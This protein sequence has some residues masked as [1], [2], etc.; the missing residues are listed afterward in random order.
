MQTQQLPPLKDLL[1]NAARELA[2]HLLNSDCPILVTSTPQR[3]SSRTS[4]VASSTGIRFKAPVVAYPDSTLFSTLTMANLQIHP[5]LQE[6][7]V[8]EDESITWPKSFAWKDW[9]PADSGTALID[10]SNYGKGDE[11]KHVSYEQ[12]REEVHR[13]LGSSSLSNIK[14]QVVGLICLPHESTFFITTFLRLLKANAI[15]YPLDPKLSSADLAQKL[16]LLCTSV[17]ICSKDLVHNVKKVLESSQTSLETVYKIVPTGNLSGHC[18]YS[19]EASRDQK[20][21]AVDLESGPE[22]T[23]T[24]VYDFTSMKRKPVLVLT[25]S[26][27]TSTPKIVPI[28]LESLLYNAKR[29]ADSLQLKRHDINL[30]VMPLFHI[31]GIMCSFLASMVAGSTV[32]CASQFEPQGFLER[33]SIYPK[34]TWYYAVPTIHKSILL[35]KQNYPRIREDLRLVR[36]GGAHLS[37][38][39]ALAL[40]AAFPK[41]TIL[42]TYS[43]SES[44]PVCSNPFGWKLQKVDTVG[45][46]IGPSV[47]IVDEQGN[48]VKYGTVG[49]VAIRGIGVTD[50]YLNRSQG[51]CFIDGEWL[52]TGDS[53]EMDRDGFLFLK[54]RLKEVAKRGGEQISLREVDE[55]LEAMPQV[56]IAVAFS[57][58]NTFWG[59][60]IAAAVVVASE[61]SAKQIIEYAKT[62]LEAYKVPAQVVVVK[63]DQIPKTSTGKYKRG[64]MAEHLSVGAVDYRAME[65]SKLAKGV[66]TPSKALYG[67]RLILAL[68]VVQHHVGIMPNKGWAIIQTFTLNMTG[69]TILAGFLLSSRTTKEVS[70]EERLDFFVTRLAAGH[71]VFLL[72]IAFALPQVFLT[73]QFDASA[74]TIVSLIWSFAITLTGFHMNFSILMYFI[75]PERVGLYTFWFLGVTWYQTMYYTCV[76]VFPFTDRIFRRLSGAPLAICTF[77]MLVLTSTLG[78]ALPMIDPDLALLNFTVVEWIWCFF[79]GNLMWRIFQISHPH[80]PRIWAVLTDTLSVGF[81]L[82][83]V[84]IILTDDTFKNPFLSEYETYLRFVV[85]R[86]NRWANEIAVLVGHQRAGSAYM[87]LWI[88][89]LAVGKGLTASLLSRK[90]LVT[91]LSPLAYSIYLFHLPLAFYYYLILHSPKYQNWWPEAGAYPIPVQWWELFIVI[92][93]TGL[94]SWVVDWFIAP[95]LVPLSLAFWRFFFRFFCCC[96]KCCC[97]PGCCCK[98][99]RRR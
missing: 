89:G 57:V 47:R 35:M 64:A 70:K 18:K 26:G 39:D 27:T 61:V 80:P 75:I 58:P 85:P 21:G 33:L 66:I 15:V 45:V 4:S 56:A 77:V 32:I 23:L 51:E 8:A 49:E 69:F 10:G 84:A 38:A 68:F 24:Q 43:M 41:A 54:G 9:F 19:L 83:Y 40:K 91:Y 88:Y 36:S 82:F 94:L 50:G 93:L 73:Y 98:P 22:L 17:V 20:A 76:L 16:E 55:A 63:E 99:P 31:G 34:P 30:N 74:A 3:I 25:T 81:V 95:R 60:E 12:L 90:F 44:M 97:D 13:D 79:L 59:E 52:R 72:A 1:H 65:A 53:G 62:K 71:G 67:L 96:C 7:L 78:W 92:L 46:P 87:T 42:P 5:E 28:C 11:M 37:H 2:R 29:I 48:T 14:D 6:V 86:W